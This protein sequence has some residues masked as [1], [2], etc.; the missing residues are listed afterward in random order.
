MYT[1]T[2]LPYEMIIDQV[3]LTYPGALPDVPADEDC[4][5]V[6]VY[7]AALTDWQQIGVAYLTEG[8]E[9]QQ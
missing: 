8:E 1:S 7:D 3:A 4:F 5:L 6:D 2:S 9:Q